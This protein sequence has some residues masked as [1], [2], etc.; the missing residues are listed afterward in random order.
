MIF[1]ILG[2]LLLLL[3]RYINHSRRFLPDFPGP[4]GC[5]VMII[6]LTGFAFVVIFIIKIIKRLIM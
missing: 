3:G 1:L 4:K 6:N 5:L 2:I